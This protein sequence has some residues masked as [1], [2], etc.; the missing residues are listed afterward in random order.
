[1]LKLKFKTM[2]QDQQPHTSGSSNLLLS[3]TSNKYLKSICSTPDKP[4]WHYKILPILNRKIHLQLT[5]QWIFQPAMLVFKVVNPPNLRISSLKTTF[6]TTKSQCLQRWH[7]TMSTT[8]NG[9]SF[10]DDMAPRPVTFDR[11][12][13]KKRAIKFA[14]ISSYG[15]STKPRKSTTRF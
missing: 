14:T 1:M 7:F 15:W 9:E 6:G 2:A 3:T 13:S 10:A 5:S 4:T 12:M 11:S 8:H